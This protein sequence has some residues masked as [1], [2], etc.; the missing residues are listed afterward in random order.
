MRKPTMNNKVVLLRVSYWWGILA[1]AAM[2]VLYLFPSLFLRFMPVNPE[3]E[4]GLKVGLLNAAPLMIGWTDRK[5]V[6][7]KVMLLLTLPVVAGY[8]LVEVSSI[9][10]GSATV[11]KMLPLLITQASMS[12]LFIYSYLNARTPAA[13]VQKV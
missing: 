7:R 1:D 4:P 10:N 3:S 5:P 2:A 6:E 9:T 8:M 12:S 11:G 13:G